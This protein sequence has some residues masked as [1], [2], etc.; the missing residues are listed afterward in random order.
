MFTGTKEER[1]KITCIFRFAMKEVIDSETP[2]WELFG[3][4]P[5]LSKRMRGTQRVVAEYKGKY[6]GRFWCGLRGI[7]EKT[8]MA[9]LKKFYNA[10][11]MRFSSLWD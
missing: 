2:R 1:E 7:C 9:F 5:K 11:E 3:I 4:V 6:D 8:R 10:L